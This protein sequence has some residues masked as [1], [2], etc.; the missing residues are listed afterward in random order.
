MASSNSLLGLKTGDIL[1]LGGLAAGAYFFVLKKPL[2]QT[3]GAVGDSL[4]AAGNVV[5]SAGNL[6][7]S[8]LDAFTPAVVN[9]GDAL[10]SA[11]GAVE[12]VAGIAQDFTKGSR[13]LL[14]DLGGRLQRG[15]D[16]SLNAANKALGK[17]FAPAP[18]LPTPPM[19]PPGYTQASFETKGKPLSTPVVRVAAQDPV[20]QALRGL[21]LGAATFIPTDAERL[22][23]NQ[24][25]TIG[26]IYP[27]GVRI[28]S[29]GISVP[30]SPAPSIPANAN[31]LA[32]NDPKVVGASIA[33]ANA[34]QA[35]KE[36]AKSQASKGIVTASVPSSSGATKSAPSS[37]SS[38][39]LA[40]ASPIYNP[41]N[42]KVVVV[43]GLTR[44][45]KR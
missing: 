2:D 8:G 33:K 38:K 5:S 41:N 36:I 26:Q 24:G 10:T 39:P 30:S 16:I 15:T 14:G 27:T 44:T 45:V 28:A 6:V 25:Y 19:Y 18:P 42:Y 9:T 22:L 31:Y 13:D 20:S 17:L 34:S 4:Q 12:N 7:S 23:L 37:S 43:N 1:L 21:G 29:S 35:A 32:G 3:T 40:K 11:S